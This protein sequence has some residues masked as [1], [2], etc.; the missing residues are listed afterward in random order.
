MQR[1]DLST[2]PDTAETS[3]GD[4]SDTSLVLRLTLAVLSIAAGLATLV[5][6]PERWKAAQGWLP[7]GRL[8]VPLALYALALV[9]VGAALLLGWRTQL[10]AIAATAITLAI[11]VEWLHLDPFYAPLPHV[12]PL[13]VLALAIIAT[14]PNGDRFGI[15]AVLPRPRGVDRRAVILLAARLFVGAT[16]L[17][18]GWT[19]T[20]R[21]AYFART[22]YVEPYRT[23]FLPEALLWIAGVANPLLQLA[24]GIALALGIRTQLAARVAGLFLVTIVFGH[25]VSDPFDIPADLHQYALQNLGGVVTVLLLARGGDPMSIDGLLRKRRAAARD[26]DGDELLG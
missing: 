19:N 25:L 8:A 13:L 7:P 23:T 1:S 14:T 24:T 9:A 11:H 22:V 16:F 21:I 10:A 20:F 17:A 15:D 2:A 3:R 26:G 5:G 4:V 6:P 18:Q 12:V